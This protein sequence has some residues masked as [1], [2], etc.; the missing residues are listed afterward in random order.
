VIRSNLTGLAL[1][2]TVRFRPMANVTLLWDAAQIGAIGDL[3]QLMPRLK[4][5]NYTM[6]IQDAIQVAAIN[7]HDQTLY[8]LFELSG[9]EI[10]CIYPTYTSTLL[11]VAAWHGNITTIEL[12]L[13]MKA[14]INGGPISEQSPLSKSVINNQNE[15]T[16]MLIAAKANINATKH[17]NFAAIHFAA[18]FNRRKQLKLLIDAKS[19]I[20]IQTSS[21]STPFAIASLYNC[22]TIMNMLLD[23]K[24]NI[25]LVTNNGHTPLFITATRTNVEALI[26]LCNMKANVNTATNR[27]ITPLYTACEFNHLNVIKILLSVKANPDVAAQN[28]IKPIHIAAINDNRNAIALLI[29]A[30]V[31]VDTPINPINCTPMHL[32]AQY[33]CINTLIYL[34]RVKANINTTT[35]GGATPIF[36]AAKYNRY[37]ILD[38]LIQSKGDLNI[39]TSTG[40]SPLC[41]AIQ[42]TH[43]DIVHKLID[44]KANVNKATTH[45]RCAP[46]HIASFHN[47]IDVLKLLLGENADPNVTLISGHMPIHYAVVNDNVSILTLLLQAKAISIPTT[48][49]ITILGHTFPINST[50]LSIAKQLNNKLIMTLLTTRNSF[51]QDNP[52][53]QKRKK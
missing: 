36:T 30:K 47:N 40:I 21:G 15:T 3:P 31:S 17:N 51:N 13:R 46:I 23:A 20:N 39:A 22:C 48:C 9:F 49:E 8:R 53:P 44:M 34:I 35:V 7:G 28:G 41:I 32:V 37:N 26:L 50:P 16:Q 29:Q 4:N 43:Y 25:N 52:P 11:G 42:Q 12:L 6:I 45:E 18:R 14:C 24:A 19:A 1:G 5:P 2:A 27:G 10:D 33:G 38:I